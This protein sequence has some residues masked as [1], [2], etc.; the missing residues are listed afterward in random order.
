MFVCSS[1]NQDDL[2][3]RGLHDASFEEEEKRAVEDNGG[4]CPYGIERMDLPF[5]S[6]LMEYMEPST[7][8]CTVPCRFCGCCLSHM[9]H[10]GVCR[11][12]VVCYLPECGQSLVGSAREDEPRGQ[13]VCQTCCAVRYC[14]LDH[15]EGHRSRHL[16]YCHS[17]RVDRRLPSPIVAHVR[18]PR[19]RYFVICSAGVGTDPI[20]IHRADVVRAAEVEELGAH[21]R[22]R[23]MTRQ[24]TELL[25]QMTPGVEIAEDGRARYTDAS[26]DAD[27]I[28]APG[29]WVSSAGPSDAVGRDE[30]DAADSSQQS[31][32]APFFHDEQSAAYRAGFEEWKANATFSYHPEYNLPL[33]ERKGAAAPRAD[34]EEQKL[35]AAP[36]AAVSQAVAAPRI[37]PRGEA[38]VS[39]VSPAYSVDSEDEKD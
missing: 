13:Y 23:G 24:F 4:C 3:R 9:P 36:A 18:H 28:R 39:P 22:E 26:A 1:M 7:T 2:P 35:A 11:E 32:A 37:V 6:A 17:H 27:T 14:C 21:F 30:D 31:G 29:R 25:I 19:L 10:L 20:L 34:E 38:P 33:D 12:V 15:Q 5:A 16:P 8:G